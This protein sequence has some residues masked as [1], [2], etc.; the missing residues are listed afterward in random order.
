M[1]NF[2]TISEISK[3]FHVTAQTLR[4]WQQENLI[5]VDKNAEN[6]YR[7]YAFPEML[8][9]SDIIF[10]R[11]LNVPI[12]KLKDLSKLNLSMIDS[13]LNETQV[14]LEE[15]IDKLINI[16]EKLKS[17]RRKIDELFEIKNN[18]YKLDF[19]D[20]D[21]I[22]SFNFTE[23]DK[24]KLYL[25]DQ[26]HYT[27]FFDKHKNEFLCNCISVPYD[28]YNSEI[29]WDK[30]ATRNKFALCIVRSAFNDWLD[31]DLDEHLS[32]IKNQ[33]YSTGTV[34]CRYLL[35]AYDNKQYD[36]FKTWIELL[37]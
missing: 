3:I 15:E 18:K 20:M 4:Y 32:F 27:I 22:V 10:Y 24:L 19:P 26:Y 6:G 28:F 7:Q 17:R 33:G 5:R 12:K 1:K 8:Q 2:F 23:E 9:I 11:S 16:N 29:L 21:K 14:D 30:N 34:I 13:M 31:N 25:E 35:S 36:Y 37:D